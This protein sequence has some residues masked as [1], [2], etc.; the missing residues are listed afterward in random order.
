MTPVLVSKTDPSQ[1]FPKEKT[2]V[3]PK[4][5]KMVV[6]EAPFVEELSGMATVKV[7]N[8]NEHITNMI[9]LKFTR[10]KVTLKTTNNT[11]ETVTFD[12]SHM[13]GILDL[14]SL[15]YYKINR[16]YFSRTWANTIT[17]NWLKMYAPN[18]TNL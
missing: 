3:P 6:V 18:S 15:G 12:R 4:V 16:T 5:Q 1:F 11:S 10:N 7:F 13:M 2:E 14:R 17:L 9:K 8:M